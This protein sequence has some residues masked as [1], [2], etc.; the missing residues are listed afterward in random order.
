MFPKL[1]QRGV[2]DADFPDLGSDVAP[3]SIAYLTLTNVFSTTVRAGDATAQ[4][5]AVGALYAGQGS[6]DPF[7]FDFYLWDSTTKRWLLLPSAMLVV[8]AGEVGYT[9]VPILVD[10]KNGSGTL[11]LAVLMTV[12]G[13]PP[14]GVY[15]AVLGTDYGGGGGAGSLPVGVASSANQVVEIARLT[16]IAGRLP[17]ALG[18]HGGLVIEGVVAGVA[19]PVSVAALP[20]LTTGAATIGAVTGPAAAPLATVAKQDEIKAA[21]NA[22]GVFATIQLVDI[23]TVD[24]VIPAGCKGLWIAVA[25]DLK[26]DGG[27]LTAQT[28]PVGVGY[29]PVPATKVYKLGTTATISFAGFAT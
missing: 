1:I 16:T 11:D 18:A 19:V 25:G 29:V 12:S 24:A 10:P 2:N 6:P 13:S 3:T 20:A 21:V 17:T 14:D 5:L 7:S 28:I 15:S 4:R 26:F 27:G 9:S 8:N 23:S 22:L